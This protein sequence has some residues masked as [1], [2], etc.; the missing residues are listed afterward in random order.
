MGHMNI[1]LAMESI[2]SAQESLRDMQERHETTSVA[3]AV[4]EVLQHLAR[5]EDALIG[6]VH[7]MGGYCSVG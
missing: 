2:L 6:V 1:R 3:S 4:L 7:E 5:A